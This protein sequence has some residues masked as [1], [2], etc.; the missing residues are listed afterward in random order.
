MTPRYH[1]LAVYSFLLA[2]IT[3]VW[4]VSSL[5]DGS[6]F[7]P[8]WIV[9]LLI[10]ACLFVW[11][12]GVPVPRVGLSSMERVPQVG[13]LLVLSPPVA[14][15]V[16]AAASLLWPLLS[17]RYSHGSARAAVLR[18]VHNASMTGL[19]LL[20]AGEAYLATGGRHPLGVPTLE[21]TGPL[22]A[23]TAVAQAVNVALLA[24]YFRLDG[25]EVR[26]VI[27]PVYTL[28]DLIFVPA[29]VLAAVLYNTAAPATFGLFAVLMVLFVFSFNGFGS[30]LHT[31]DATAEALVGLPDSPR[32]LHGARRIDELGERIL[33]EVRALLRFDVCSLAIVDTERKT[34][35]LRVQERAGER[36]PGERRALDYG[37][38]GWVAA[39][40]TAVLVE[41]WARA[42]ESL[43]AAAAAADIT[44]GSMIL[45]PLVDEG[46]VLGV[47]GVRH[48]RPSAYSDADLHLMQ[49]LAEQVAP[50]LSDAGA[51]EDLEDYRRR[52]EQR[53]AERTRE[54]DRANQEKERLIDALGER[55]RALERESQEDPLTAI[56]NRRAFGRRL[57]A[58]ID[59]A[60][61]MGQPL[62]LAVADLDHFKIVNDRM[63]HGVG[64]EVLRRSAAVMQRH[65]RPVDLV[66]RIGGEEFAL[67]LP[68]LDLAAAT[69]RCESLRSAVELHPWANVHPGLRV[70]LSIGIAQWDGAC[71]ADELVHAADT[72][73]YSAK[74]AG[75]NRVA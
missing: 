61:A 19:M 17:R 23:M 24:A 6:Q 43:R 25:R 21:D 33:S 51:F 31:A 13:M 54:L 68:G 41:D 55:S 26:R 22:L 62:A 46:R 42:P 53:V 36:M 64:D 18:A 8:V 37:P 3:A 15:A 10:A 12:F 72:R 69:A 67:I 40:G 39:R 29:G 20:L 63:G 34:L 71:G 14:A 16:C 47:L 60:R 30:A 73:L 49:R 58:E 7:P 28:V 66:A 65:C 45:V 11:Q 27:R 70:T 57:A 56:A 32:P 74:H 52:L 44:E 59:V 1:W 48:A 9:V 35:D 50:A 75:R 38:F 2:A 5:A 4:L